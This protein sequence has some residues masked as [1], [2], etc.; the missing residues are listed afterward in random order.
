MNGTQ[1][2]PKV[3]S[4]ADTTLTTNEACRAY[5]IL[6]VTNGKGCTTSPLGPCSNYSGDVTACIGYIGSDGLCTGDEGGTKCRIKQCTDSA[7]SNNTDALCDAFLTG[8]VTKGKGC[9]S[10]LGLCSSYTG[11]ADVSC[12]GLIG[13]DG[14][15]K[16]S[17]GPCSVKTCTDA[18]TT[19]KTDFAC[20]A[21]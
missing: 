8:C 12:D 21:F 18:P 5:S 1:C 10:A 6:C 16:G 3:C 11:T 19:T 2:K 17:V 9:I 7:I 15:C 4:E 20:N 13:S 14:Y